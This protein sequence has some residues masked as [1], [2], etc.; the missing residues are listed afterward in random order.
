[1]LTY[2]LIANVFACE[3]A[4]FLAIAKGRY[5]WAIAYGAVGLGS[6]I[7]VAP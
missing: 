6:L 1:M 2:F 5:L 4:A 7:L 3:A